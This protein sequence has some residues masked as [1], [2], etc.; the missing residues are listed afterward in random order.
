VAGERLQDVEIAGDQRRLGD[1][2]DR[3]AVIRGQHLQDP[4]GEPEPPL[5]RLIGVGGSADHQRLAGQASRVERSGQN[6]GH[7]GFDQDLFF[8]SLFRR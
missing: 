5:G 7:F 8:E 2:L 1:D 4:A 6:V 3:K